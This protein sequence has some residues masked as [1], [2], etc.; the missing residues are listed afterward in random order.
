M[1]LSLPRHVHTRSLPDWHWGARNQLVGK[2]EGWLGGGGGWLGGEGD[3]LRR[4]W[5]SNGFIIN[6]KIEHRGPNFGTFLSTL[7]QLTN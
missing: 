2:G 7:L 6:Y 3:G 1:G 5:L 4:R